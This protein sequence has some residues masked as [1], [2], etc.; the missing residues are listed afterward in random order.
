MVIIALLDEVCHNMSLQVVDIDEGYAEA[1]SETLGEANANEQRAHQAG[2]ASEGNGR[3]LFLGDAGTAYG[4]VYNGYHVL[5][6]G[7]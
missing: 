7:S 2:P 1:T 5:L 3:E 4:L 6:V